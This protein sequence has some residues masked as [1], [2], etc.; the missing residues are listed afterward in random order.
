VNYTRNDWYVACTERDLAGGGPVAASIL[1]EGIVIW[2]SGDRIVVFEDRCVHRAAA[3]SLGRC[4]GVHLRCM[5]HGL[6]FDDAGLVVEI[7]GQDVIPPN[8]RVRSYPVAVRHGWVW[9]WMGD[10]ARADPEMLPGFYPG[11]DLHHFVTGHGVLDFAADSR[12]ISDNLLDFSHL[13]F[14]HESSFRS[15]PDWAHSTM[16][17]EQLDRGMRF[18][19]WIENAE[20]NHLFDSQP[21]EPFDSWLGYDYLVPGVLLMWSGIFRGGSARAADFGRPD[22]SQAIGQVLVNIQA[23][24]PTTERSSRYHFTAGA[25]R[26][27]GDGEKIVDPL[28]DVITRAF[29]EDKRMIEAQQRVLDR[30]PQRPIMPTTHDRGVTLYNRLR[31]RLIAA[32]REAAASNEQ[33]AAE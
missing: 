8:A 3:L 12:L 17:M 20:G 9:G 1:G 22:F 30:D 29:L 23:I 14:V 16:K 21:T 4:E 13:P 27:L 33:V 28:V 5:Y 10:P 6:L 32:E 18:E 2:R 24:T 19:R 11:V 25:H 15:P 31:A 7:P 26:E